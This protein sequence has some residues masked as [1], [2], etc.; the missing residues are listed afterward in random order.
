MFTWR[1]DMEEGG[2]EMTEQ[3]RGRPGEMASGASASAGRA[4]SDAKQ[5]AWRTLAVSAAV[6]VAIAVLT[7]LVLGGGFRTAGLGAPGD[8]CGRPVAGISGPGNAPGQ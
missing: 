8:C 2:A 6:A 3:Q 7:T 1:L 4:L 5:F